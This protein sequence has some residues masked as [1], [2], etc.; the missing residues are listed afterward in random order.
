[1]EA[2]RDGL[3]KLSGLFRKKKLD[4][5]EDKDFIMS[6]VSG[7]QR[8]ILRHAFLEYL[9]ESNVPASEAV[10]YLRAISEPCS[11][12]EES[13]DM[14]DAPKL[15]QAAVHLLDDN[16]GDEDVLQTG[17]EIWDNIYRENRASIQGLSSLLDNM[18]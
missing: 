4:P 6:L 18:E 10:A 9:N 14:F 1:M 5:Q 3:M 2:S 15:A 7:K 11:D 13:W 12:E 17:L 8:R 16:R